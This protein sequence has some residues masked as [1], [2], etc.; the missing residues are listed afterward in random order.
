MSDI[1]V[2]SIE[3]GDTMHVMHS[4]AQMGCFLI[5]AVVCAL[6]AMAADAVAAGRNGCRTQR[7]VPAYRKER[8]RQ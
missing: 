6:S 4:S 8:E 3:A 1:G 5:F 2:E 7:S